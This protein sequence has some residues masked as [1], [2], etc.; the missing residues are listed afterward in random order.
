MS[1]NDFRVT[2]IFRII[3]RIYKRNVEFCGK[4]SKYLPKK[5]KIIKYVENDIS[6]STS[7]EKKKREQRHNPTSK[8]RSISKLLKNCH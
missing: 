3:I 7:Q 1:E 8:K 6:I 2:S 4:T 5:I